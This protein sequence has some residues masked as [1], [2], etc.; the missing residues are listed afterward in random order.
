MR[1]SGGQAAIPLCTKDSVLTD[2]LMT[3]ACAE[4]PET[5]WKYPAFRAQLERGKNVMWCLLS[6]LLT[7]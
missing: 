6:P 3:P 5:R 2:D 4:G 7:V 1:D